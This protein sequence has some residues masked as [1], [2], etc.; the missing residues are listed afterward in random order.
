M[1]TQQSNHTQYEKMLAENTELKAVNAELAEALKF[2][3]KLIFNS[4]MIIGNDNAFLIN[5]AIDRATFMNKG[6]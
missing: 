6:E 2:A 3:R 5:K 4:G 1:T